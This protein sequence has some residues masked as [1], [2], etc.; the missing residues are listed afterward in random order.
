MKSKIKTIDFK[1]ISLKNIKL[2]TLRFKITLSIIP[3]LLL[4]VVGCTCFTISSLKDIS[5]YLIEEKLE[6]NLQTTEDLMEFIISGNW[7]VKNGTLHKGDIQVE[8]NY[9][10]VDI[11][12]DKTGNIVSIFKDDKIVSTTVRVR[13]SRNVGVKA[14][15]KVI[16]KVLKK[17]GVYIEES[18]IEGKKYEILYKPL[19][20]K[21]GNVIGMFYMGVDKTLI[22]EKINSVIYY[23]LLISSVLLAI[24]II[25]I[26]FISKRI[27]NPIIGIK[28][29]LE[30]MANGEGDLTK[31]LSINTKD[32]IG[33]L[34]K[35]FNN[36][37]DNLNNLISDIKMSAQKLSSFNNE[38][39][40][41]I[42]VSNAS[43]QQIYAVSSSISSKSE[44]NIDYINQIENSIDSISENAQFTAV[45]IEDV[46]QIYEE[47]KI[48][49]KK[50]ETNIK[51]IV[52]SVNDIKL[53][54]N[55]LVDVLEKLNLSSE[56][57]VQIVEVI[58]NISR[59][60]NLLALN[61]S[62]EAARAGE[63][64]RGFEVVAKEIRKLA[65]ETNNSARSISEI[66][67]EFKGE[68]QKVVIQTSNVDGKVNESVSRAEKVKN[69][70]LEIINSI[71]G[72]SYKIE[73][74]SSV[75][76]EQAASTQ[77][78]SSSTTSIIDGIRWTGE[79]M[80]NIGDNIE[81]QSKIFEELSNSSGEIVD[82][83]SYLNDLVG[84]FKTD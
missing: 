60:T 52:Y 81:N 61:A 47:L 32:E 25:I 19:R 22:E 41:S 57:I 44:E 43:M 82:M 50:G 4:I 37:L 18:I 14:P 74:I 56:K 31:R 7:N 11:L 76:N 6:S 27:T 17:E 40:I 53:L 1:S 38:I 75:A 5:F 34:S 77:E 62:I 67:K 69:S 15:K 30:E 78:I 79:E 2:D 72:V 3:A 33:Q 24:S 48:E 39:A 84:R 63:E 21:D 71:V 29:Q 13:G 55:N 59:Q 68:I 58:S 54:T 12:S 23:S 64:G 49:T 45:S 20:D 51:E 36:F 80:I 46:H 16:D 65:D 8:G 83:S 66:I 73:G 26:G 70:I 28:S 35:E 42:D 9:T 10:L